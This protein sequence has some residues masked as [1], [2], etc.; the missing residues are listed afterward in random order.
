M[1][2]VDRTHAVGARSWLASANRPDIDFPIQNL[3]FGVFRRAGSDE[4][5]RGGVPIGDQVLDLAAL[6]ELD[7]LSGLAAEAACACAAPELNAF[8]ALGPA[9]WRALRHALFDLL[10]EEVATA[11]PD[12]LAALRARLVP[13]AEVECAVPARVGD[14][15]DFYTSI[16]HARSIS[17]LM[18]EALGQIPRN[19][20][21][22]PTA[23]HGRVSSIG[24]S[25]QT[26]RRP[27]GQ[28]LRAGR[29]QPE[30]RPTERLDYELELGIWIGCGNAPGETI[31]LDDAEDH[32]FGV[33]LLNDW[34]ARDIQA[35]ELVPLGPFHAK[36]FATTVS[37]W[38]VT[39]D[40]L[41][42]YRLPWSRP[43]NDPQPLS[44]LD[45]TAHRAGGALDVTLEVR[46]QTETMRRRGQAEHP[47]SRSNFRHHYW[48][49]A[50]MVT[51]H[52]AG[53]CNLRVGDLLGSG[54]VSGPEQSEAGALIELALAGQAPVCLAGGET[55]SFLEDGD[56]VALHGWCAG[57]E[58]ARIGFGA[59][60]G[61]VLPP[62]PIHPKET[63]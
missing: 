8:L 62:L 1:R 20:Q 42:P 40:A 36:N 43:A 16:H 24:V 48:S 3:P 6:A 7:C 49:V 50:Q 44:Y 18:P 58:R 10:H 4:S 17:R 2:T 21:W 35:W 52:A 53:G 47:V 23:Y 22:I 57:R 45:S 56:S 32:V 46:I 25:G 15:T 30:Y 13:I 9:A 37:P 28:V 63:P 19:F 29:T 31:E 5:F 51:H 55:R 59:A 26:F 60:R 39:L 12:V 34:S 61:L 54:T 33:S 14:Y 41:V 11:R 38:I 27:R